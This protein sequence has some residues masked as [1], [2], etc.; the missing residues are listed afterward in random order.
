LIIVVLL[1]CSR[2]RAVRPDAAPRIAA[3]QVNG[4]HRILVISRRAAWD[5][6][7]S[8]LV[9]AEPAKVRAQDHEKIIVVV[10]ARRQRQS[11]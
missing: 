11:L 10:V 5:G 8:R 1:C 9:H 6:A 3:V 2:E 7:T 4:P